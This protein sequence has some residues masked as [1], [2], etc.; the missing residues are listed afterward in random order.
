[1]KENKLYYKYRDIFDNK[2]IE[3]LEEEVNSL[4][5]IFPFLSLSAGTGLRLIENFLFSQDLLDKLLEE[6]NDIRIEEL[7]KR[8][9]AR[10][11]EGLIKLWKIRGQV[12]G[13]L[14]EVKYGD[15]HFEN[16]TR[17]V[18]LFWENLDLDGFSRIL[19]DETKDGYSDE[20]FMEAVELYLAI[21]RYTEN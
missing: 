5:Q 4:F 13:Q 7:K 8:E 21:R 18:P 15:W 1:M 12:N 9:V 19:S 2:S 16:L 10:K 3:Q 20:K 17:D 14:K 6:I 11:N